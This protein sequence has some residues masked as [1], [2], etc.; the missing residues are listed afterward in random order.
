MRKSL[1]ILLLLSVMVAS[2]GNHPASVIITAGQSNADGRVPRTDLPV[3]YVYK[4]CLWSYNSGVN[5]TKGGFS[6][7]TPKTYQKNQTD[8]WGFDATTYYKLDSVMTEPFYVIKETVGGTAIDPSITN[9]KYG[10][11][12]SADET[13]LSNNVSTI[14]GGLSLLKAWSQSIDACISTTLDTLPSGYDFK[15][16]LWHQGESDT[17]AA[18]SYHDNLRDVVKYMRRYLVDRTGNSSYADI[19]FICGTISQKSSCYNKI[20]NDAFYT[21]ASE[22]KHFYVVDM[23]KTALQSDNLHFTATS[24]EYLGTQMFQLLSELGVVSTGINDVSVVNVSSDDSYYNLQGQK[25]VKG[26]RGLYIHQG[27]KIFIQ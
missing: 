5:T 20:I 4:N 13:W 24:A 3:S 1:F 11:L 16:I 7:F 8:R 22:D 23:S 12:W 6:V 14:N 9:S 2:A 19:P 10:F 21:L 26:Q 27:I 17:A 18:A 25:V 15:A